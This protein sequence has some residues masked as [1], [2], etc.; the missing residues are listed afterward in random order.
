MPVAGARPTDRAHVRARDVPREPAATHGRTEALVALLALAFPA[1]R[2]L[3]ACLQAAM[4]FGPLLGGQRAAGR[5][6]SIELAACC[7]LA[8][9]TYVHESYTRSTLLNSQARWITYML[10]L[11]SVLRVCVCACVG[12]SMSQ[13][14][15]RNDS[16]WRHFV[17]ANS[18]GHFLAPHA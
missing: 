9:L 3:L 12:L 1:C 10:V 15:P 4:P 13:N 16:S 14:L 5:R 7:L 17:F 6:G 18:C 8:A 2:W 11:V